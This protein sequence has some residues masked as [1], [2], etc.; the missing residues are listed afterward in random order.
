[1]KLLWSIFQAEEGFLFFI[2]IRST[3]HKEVCTIFN[4]YQHGVPNKE[5][6]SLNKLKKHSQKAKV[7]YD[8]KNQNSEVLHDRTQENGLEKNL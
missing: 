6:P 8:D 2:I 3:W 1:M 7:F 4:E 5:L